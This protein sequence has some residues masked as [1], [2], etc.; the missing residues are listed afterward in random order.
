MLD[1]VALGHL[2]SVTDL[3]TYLALTDEVWQ[4]FLQV[5]GDPGGDFRPLA[6][7]PRLVVVEAVSKTVLPSGLA[8]SPV[9]AA[10]VGLMWRSARMVVHLRAGGVAE[11][12]QD[13]D[14]WSPGG[15]ADGAPKTGSSVKEKVLKMA[16]LVDQ[17]DESEFLPAEPM[18]IQAWSQHYVDI[19]GAPPE[20]EEEPTDAQ[21]G[22]LHKRVMEQGHAPYVDFGVWGPYGRRMLKAQKYR[23]HVPLG[24]GSFLLK[25]M[26]G[27]QNLQQWTA[28]WRVFKVAAISMDLVSIAALQLYE[29]NIEKLVLTWPKCWGLIAA[30]DDKGRSEKLEK[31]RRRFLSDELSGKN[32]PADWSRDA[33]WTC[34]F[35]TLAL[36]E[37]YWNEEVRHPAAAWRGL[38]KGKL[39]PL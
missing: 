36:E 31:I 23:T 22:A 1:P 13:V 25:E 39:G 3:Q 38:P 27:P 10:Q 33:P 35:K 29:K 19:M 37:R 26:P 4:A 17:S 9:Q 5:I 20:E 34:C 6:A 21:M 30:A 2:R 12:F 14:P 32:T 16:S 11:E 28:C 15:R 8:L 7:L 18:M 24:D